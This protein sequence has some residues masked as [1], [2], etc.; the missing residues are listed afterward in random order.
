MS[1]SELK[2]KLIN[3]ITESNN[4]ELLLEVYRLM[5]IESGDATPYELSDIQMT[6]VRESQADV[7]AGK[8]LTGDAANKEIDE[9]LKE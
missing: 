3:E 1:P 8:Y 4:E 7:N 5:E 2:V 6:V 9:W